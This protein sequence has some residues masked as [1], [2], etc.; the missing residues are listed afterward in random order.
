MNTMTRS[1]PRQSARK[2]PNLAPR[3]VFDAVHDL[4]HAIRFDNHRREITGVNRGQRFIELSYLTDHPWIQKRG[5]RPVKLS[6][7]IFFLPSECELAISLDD[8]ST[9]EFLAYDLVGTVDYSDQE[10]LKKI[11]NFLYNNRLEVPDDLKAHIE[12]AQ[13]KLSAL[14][15]KRKTPKKQPG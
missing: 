13:V 14:L 4:L 2:T 9:R 8:L 6:P 1:K 5:S 12:Q 3:Q 11:F 7:L 15:R 10:L